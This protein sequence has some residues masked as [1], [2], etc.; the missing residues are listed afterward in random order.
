MLVFPAF[1]F[2]HYVVSPPTWRREFVK[3]GL[4]YQELEVSKRLAFWGRSKLYPWM[5]DR[6]STLYLFQTIFG[7]SQDFIF[8]MVMGVA[9]GMYEECIRYIHVPYDW[10]CPQYTYTWY[11]YR[12]IYTTYTHIHS[13]R[14]HIWWVYY[15]VHIHCICI[16]IL[17]RRYLDIH[18]HSSMLV[19]Y[20]VLRIG[21][22]RHLVKMFWGFVSVVS[23]HR[24]KNV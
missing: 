18:M 9:V 3:K 16:H 13:R 8:W 17:F 4:P 22:H 5:W 12:Y 7:D 24:T 14:A 10:L 2:P 21:V 15:H 23:K 6:Y 1:F 20:K 19:T 11:I